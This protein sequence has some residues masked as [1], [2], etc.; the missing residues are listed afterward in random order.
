[1][2]TELVLPFRKPNDGP[3]SEGITYQ[4]LLDGDTRP[5]PDVLRWQSARDLPTARVPISRYVSR[6]FHD[7]EQQEAAAREYLA[8]G[9]PEECRRAGC[10]PGWLR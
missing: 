1:M 4:Q 8:T 7:L 5:V 2:A 9:L 3:R 6:E 10:L